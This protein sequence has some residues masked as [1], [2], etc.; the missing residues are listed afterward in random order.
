M[1]PVTKYYWK[2]G[3]YNDADPVLSTIKDEND[4]TLERMAEDRL[5]IGSAADCV[6]QVQRWNREVGADYFVL[7]FRHAHAGGPPHAAVCRAI[8][9]FGSEVI[10]PLSATTPRQGDAR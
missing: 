4:V 5:I 9:L 10:R 1:L 2:N 6:E 7:R 3:A 8:E